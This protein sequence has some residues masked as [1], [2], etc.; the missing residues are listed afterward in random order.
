[1]SQKCL[2]MIGIRFILIKI[3]LNSMNRATFIKSTLTHIGSNSNSK[4]TRTCFPTNFIGQL[5]SRELNLFVYIFRQAF[6]WLIDCHRQLITVLAILVDYLKLVYK[7][8]VFVK[9][10]SSGIVLLLN[11]S[12]LLSSLI[13]PMLF[14]ILN[15]LKLLFAL[16]N[17]K[18]I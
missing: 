17:L 10:L 15:F 8:Q 6:N 1:M 7:L 12:A 5:R 18:V 9:L 13:N 2:L 3:N 14:R 16:L 4:K 11:I